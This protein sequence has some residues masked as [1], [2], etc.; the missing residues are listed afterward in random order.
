MLDN[1]A[2]TIRE[3]VR[4]RGGNPNANGADGLGIVISLLPL[5]LGAV[6]FVMNQHIRVLFVHLIGK[7]MLGVALAGQVIGI[8]VIRRIVNIEV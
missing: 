1:I 3:R 5:V 8:L 6:I 7:I 4:I 2:K